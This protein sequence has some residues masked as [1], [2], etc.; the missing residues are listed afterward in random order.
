MKKKLNCILLIDDDEATNYMH[1][2]IIK[3]NDCTNTIV[4]K[5]NGQLALDYLLSIDDKGNVQPDIIFLDINMH[6]MNG[7]GFLKHYN[8]LN[9]EQQAKIVVVML[10]TSTDPVDVEKAK[11]IEYVSRF[12]PK[13]LTN[14]M[15]NDIL[16]EHFPQNF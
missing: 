10:S 1:Q 15:L 3:K 8:K 16:K 14:N 2:L 9:K 13:P 11:D 12:N 7:W 6:G 5:Q 4:C